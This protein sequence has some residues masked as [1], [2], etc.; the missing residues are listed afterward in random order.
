[1]IPGWQDGNQAKQGLVTP[2]HV[3]DNPVMAPL[4][5]HLEHFDHLILTA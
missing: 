2:V 3:T 1:M 4:G 5:R